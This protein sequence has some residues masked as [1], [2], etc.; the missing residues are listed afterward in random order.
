MKKLTISFW[1]ALAA[2]GVF[3][4]KALPSKHAPVAELPYPTCPPGCPVR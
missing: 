2:A 3:A 4:T 1:L